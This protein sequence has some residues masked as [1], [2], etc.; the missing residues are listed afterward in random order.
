[1]KKR[2]LKLIA[3]AALIAVMLAG[4]TACE[5]EVAQPSN[6]ES[7]PECLSENLSGDSVVGGVRFKTH[8]H[9]GLSKGLV[10][11]YQRDFIET[12][13]AYF[14]EDETKTFE[15]MKVYRKTDP[16]KF[17]YV[18]TTN[19]DIPYPYDLYINGNTL[20]STT[21]SWYYANDPANIDIY[22]WL[23]T[24][25]G[26]KA[27]QNSIYMKMKRYNKDGSIQRRPSRVFGRLMTRRDMAD[28]LEIA[29]LD[30][31]FRGPNVRIH[32][33]DENYDGYY[34][35]FVFGLDDAKPSDAI[36]SL[37]GYRDK[38]HYPSDIELIKKK[39]PTF[40]D[41]ELKLFYNGYFAE[42]DGCGKYW[43]A[44]E[45]VCNYLHVNRYFFMEDTE[46]WTAYFMMSG[47]VEKG[48]PDYGFSVR[49]VFD[50]FM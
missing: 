6:D 37:G 20:T 22:G 17:F 21:E 5:E 39:H 50:P 40:T 25:S 41:S 19:L 11:V 48:H 18:M 8:R 24:R 4:I 2:I 44:E 32:E 10:T 27:M 9:D 16:T 46:E 34:D 49:Y 43:M 29:N 3:F 38:Y 13:E 35:A 28:I 47:P 45:R 31:I 1:M 12:G 36:H 14:I 26:A 7:K 30:D 23:Y 42:K 15:T 33:G